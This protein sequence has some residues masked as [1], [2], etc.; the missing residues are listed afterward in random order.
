MA[1]YLNDILRLDNLKNVKIRLN[2]L[3]P[4]RQE[5]F[6]PL[7]LVQHDRERLYEGHFGDYPDQGKSFK[8]GQTVLGFA[9]IGGNAWL[10]FDIS[11][12]TEAFPLGNNP[13]YKYEPLGEYEKYLYRLVVQYHNTGMNLI[14]KA[15]GLIDQLE[16][17][18]ILCGEFNNDIFP[19]YE[20]V[21]V[22]WQDLSR[23]VEKDAWKTALQNQ[24]G[25]YLITDI[26]TNKRYV[27][28]ASGK[29]MLLGRWLD[30]IKNGH[31]GDV[32]LKKLAQEKGFDY[33]KH[34]FRYAILDIFK[35]TIEEDVIRRRESWWKEALLTRRD[36][37]GYNRN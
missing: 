22:S 15:E 24:K 1:I 12:I 35:S 36:D 26:A 23:L 25:V 7:E 28:S 13:P 6:N 32:E 18:Q 19:G 21:D 27:G 20:N 5:E 34:N 16:V 14:R 10:L 4:N 17:A 31:G 29:D 11:K 3:N 30:Y 8:Q 2:K 9:H 33:I 37:Y